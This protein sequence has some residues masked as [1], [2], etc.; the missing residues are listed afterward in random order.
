[1]VVNVIPRKPPLIK[2]FPPFGSLHLIL[3]SFSDRIWSNLY[4]AN[5]ILL[6]V[7]E[8]SADTQGLG[9]AII[10]S[11]IRGIAVP[12]FFEFAGFDFAI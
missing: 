5:A 11:G 8:L 1:M 7:K 3:P 10:M 9:S 6:F 2:V 12:F 4:R